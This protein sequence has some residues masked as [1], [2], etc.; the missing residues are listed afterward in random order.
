MERSIPYTENANVKALGLVHL[1]NNKGV[2]AVAGAVNEPR[3]EW[4]EMSS[5]KKT[6]A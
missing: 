1:R 6:K 3:K 4:Q 5:E 2:V